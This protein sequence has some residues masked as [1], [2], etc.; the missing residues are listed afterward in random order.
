MAALGALASLL[1]VVLLAPLVRARSA[2]MAAETS[3]GVGRD[4][5]GIDPADPY[6]L[7]LLVPGGRDGPMNATLTHR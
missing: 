2:G 3:S 7:A 4:P 5:G 6:P 1:V